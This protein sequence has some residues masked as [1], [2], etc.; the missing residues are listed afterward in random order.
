MSNHRRLGRRDFLKLS[1]L[2]GAAALTA[3][4]PQPPSTPTQAPAPAAAPTSG[5]APAPAPTA[6]A[7]PKA[8]PKL[9]QNLIGKLEGPTIV[10]DT[11]KFPK[12][13]KEAPALAD[14]V[15]AGKLPPVEA[16]L[17]QPTDV[18][19]I[20]PVEGVGKYGGTWRR[21][22]TG[23]ADF[24]NGDRMISLDKIL[25]LDYTGT[26]N[27][28]AVAKDWKISD[29]GKSTTIYLRKGMKWS[30]GQPFNADDIMFWYEDIYNNKDLVPVKTPEMFVNGKEGRI[31]KVDD[32][33][34]ALEFDDPYYL[35]EDIL[36]GDTSLGGGQAWRARSFMG[37]YSPAHYMKQFHPKYTSKAELDKKVADA[38]A[39]GW[40]V[41]FRQKSQWELNPELPMLGPWRTTTPA[42]NP[43]W[44]LERNPYFWAVDT[45]GNQLPYLDKVQLTIGENLE[46]INLRAIAGEYDYQDRHM[47]AAKLPVFLENQKK[48]GYTTRLDPQNIGATQ[49]IFFNQSYEGDAE[50]AKWIKTADFR[51]AL[52][53]G[54]DRAQLVE[55]FA[56]GVGEPGSVCPP[57]DW[58]QSP[59]ADWKKKWSTLDIKAAN[60]LLDKIGL[61]KK[62]G[63]GFR[64]RTDGKGRLRLEWIV[65]G[66]NMA[67]Y[68]GVAEM[69]A[70][71]W[72]KIGIQADIKETERSLAQTRALNGEHQLYS[73]NNS[74]AELLYLFPR[75]AIPV[76]PTEAYLGPA[77]AKWFA[78]GGTAGKKPDDPEMLKA[79]DLFR[80]A[81][82]QKADQRIKTAQEIWKILVDQQYAVGL[83]G[84]S[85]TVRITNDK[86]GNV[87]GRQCADQNCRTPGSSMPATFFFK[88]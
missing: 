46:I 56:L 62:D 10:R 58:P 68:T 22:F 74:G 69:V 50:I 64:L 29:D 47:D 49:E 18:L 5:P 1:A 83:W 35:L 17:P 84:S 27:Q 6:A 2:A 16:R 87:P 80:S 3:C 8:E 81:A 60:D 70:T 61:D 82:G 7:A 73:W 42:N 11:A 26:K 48:Y 79:Y 25:H 72:K 59:G 54:I 14:L 78:S 4:T 36:G 23:P 51:R 76:E 55:T 65:V 75:H 15:K 20:Q 71:Q 24:E 77:W 37:L 13:F 30:D 33:T 21:A 67:N 52:S 28:P 43:T 9:G 41:L 57:A 32:Y 53:M 44:V 19:V 39:D 88:S 34:V 66:A 45:E 31:K 38:K 86:L 63:D 40:V 85:A 12:S